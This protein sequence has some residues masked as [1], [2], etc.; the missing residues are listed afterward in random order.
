QLRLCIVTGATHLR[1]SCS[2]LRLCIVTG[3]THPAPLLLI[4]S[5]CI[6][7]RRAWSDGQRRYTVGWTP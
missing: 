6:V 4:A 2:S 3:A 7:T 5:L 1:R